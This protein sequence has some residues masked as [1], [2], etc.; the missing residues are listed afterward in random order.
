MTFPIHSELTG[1]NLH[2]PKA[3][4][5]SHE[6]GGSDAIDLSKVSFAS[7]LMVSTNY[8]DAIIEAFNHGGGGSGVWGS[9]TGTIT[10]QADLVNLL[11]T[12]FLGLSDTPSSYS[13]QGL[14]GVRVNSGETGLEFY[15]V[16]DTDEKVKVDSESTAGYLGSAYNDGVLRTSSPLTFVDGGNYITLGIQKADTS[17]NGYLSSDDWNTFNNKQN[18]FIIDNEYNCLI[19]SY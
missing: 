1:A 14:K 5:S 17:T 9:I 18:V 15:T 6:S 2:N 8:Y 7:E 3:H 4:V 16:V 12:T 13:A 11:V 19:G 10:D